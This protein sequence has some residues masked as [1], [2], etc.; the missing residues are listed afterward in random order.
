[1]RTEIKLSLYLLFAIG[2]C[3]FGFFA[4]RQ[5]QNV[6]AVAF[7]TSPVATNETSRSA[8]NEVVATRGTNNVPMATNELVAATN[9]TTSD[10]PQK[11]AERPPATRTS[12]NN[13]E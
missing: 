12:Q 10:S 8:S 6:T 9:I 5:Y 3:V 13:S 7:G 2:A 1:M 11:P 4:R